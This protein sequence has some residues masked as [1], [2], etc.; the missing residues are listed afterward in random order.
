MRNFILQIP[1]KIYF[2][3]DQ[4]GHLKEELR[5]YGTNVLLV[6]GGG[7]IKKTGLYDRIAREVEEADRKS[8][9]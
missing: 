8:V 1:T 7:S 9:V 6:Y 5:K 3:D 2:G 4:M